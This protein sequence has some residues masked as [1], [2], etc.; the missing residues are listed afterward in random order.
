MSRRTR[1]LSIV[2]AVLVLAVVELA[3]QY[4]R[5]RVACVLVNNQSS[6][7]IEGLTITCDT[8]SARAPRILAGESVKLY[9]AGGGNQVLVLKYSHKGSALQGFQVA[10]FDLAAMSRERS[11]LVINIRSNEFERYQEEDEP[12][13]LRRAGAGFVHWLESS[14]ESP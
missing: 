6:E 3:Y 5:P 11:R 10:G 8:S 13:W 9:L 1:N 7:P 14:L 2:I 12:S 4:Q